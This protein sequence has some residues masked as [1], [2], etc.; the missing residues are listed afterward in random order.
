MPSARSDGIWSEQAAQTIVGKVGFPSSWNAS[1]LTLSVRRVG[2]DGVVTTSGDEAVRPSFDLA[3]IRSRY[4]VPSTRPST[5]ATCDVASASAG[6]QIV[7][8]SRPYAICELTGS[9]VFHSIVAL[10]GV[11]ATV[12]TL[13][14]VIGVEF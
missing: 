5:V 2:S 8:L 11:T 12:W 9:L 3:S 14:I 1:L 7:G 6:V 10:N 13:P 4:D